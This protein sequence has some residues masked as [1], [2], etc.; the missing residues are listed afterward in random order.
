[1]LF[2]C[3]MTYNAIMVHRS[4]KRRSNTSS[5][6]VRSKGSGGSRKS[7]CIAYTLEEMHPSP[8]AFS[9]NGDRIHEQA[10]CKRASDRA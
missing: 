3:N 4:P 6:G 1:M 9:T 7:S 10:R 2:E 5:Y 8:S